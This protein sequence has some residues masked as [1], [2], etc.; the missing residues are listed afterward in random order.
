LA[1]PIILSRARFR[2]RQV[3]EYVSQQ[4]DDRNGE[5]PYQDATVVVLSAQQGHGFS[6]RGEPFFAAFQRALG[7]QVRCTI[8]ALANGAE[9]PG[10]TTCIFTPNRWSDYAGDDVLPQVAVDQ[11]QPVIKTVLQPG[12]L[13]TRPENR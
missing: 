6:D 12:Y 8:I 11:R 1:I 2:N 3:P 9:L 5:A 4:Q 7:V 13:T 10:R